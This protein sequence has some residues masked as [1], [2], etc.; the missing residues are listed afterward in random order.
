MDDGERLNEVRGRIADDTG[1]A[2]VLVVRCWEPAAYRVDAE[3]GH[4]MPMAD[5]PVAT[6]LRGALDG[7]LAAWERGD[8]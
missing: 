6:T 1:E 4:G 3:T 2:V 8:E 5:G 7:L